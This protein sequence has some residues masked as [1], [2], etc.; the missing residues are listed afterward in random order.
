MKSKYGKMIKGMNGAG[1]GT[2]KR[3]AHERTKKKE[4]GDVERE[5]KIE[6][7]TGKDER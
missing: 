2:K 7:I 6:S 1:R 5:N 3:W 4:I